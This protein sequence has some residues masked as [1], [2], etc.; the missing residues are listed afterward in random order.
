[1]EHFEHHP[2]ARVRLLVSGKAD[3]PVLGIAQAF[4]VDT[5]VLDK[6]AFSQTDALLGELEAYP[7]DFIALAGFMWKIPPY[8]V[9]AYAGR[10]VNIHPA[11]LPKFGGKGMY[12][13]HVHEAVIAA[14][15]R[16][17]GITIHWV[18]E[19]YDEGAIIFQTACPVAADDTPQDLARKVQQLEHQY[20]PQVIEELV[21][22]G[23]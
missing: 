10:M 20:Y 9:Q 13:M 7:I 12:G 2:R 22:G 19:H 5:R 23:L 21:F 8:L 1:M 17:S 15:E 16:Q 11:L 18:N 4:G 14:G 6:T 3:A